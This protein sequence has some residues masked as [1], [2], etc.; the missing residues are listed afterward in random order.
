[1]NI[2][3]YRKQC[4]LTFL[5]VFSGT[6]LV[7][8]QDILWDKSY[9]GIHAEYLF[10]AQ[11]T[12]DYGFILVGSSISDRSGNKTEGN[13]Y[14]LDYWI[15]K[16]DEKG[17]LDWQ[18]SFGGNGND[19]LKSIDLTQDGGFI[20]GGHSTSMEGESKR[21]DTRGQ[22]DLWVIKLNARGDEE[23]QKTIGGSGKDILQQIKQTRDGGYI[24]GASSS[25]RPSGE[26]K[27]AHY[28][29]MDFWV[30][31]L[32]PQGTVEWERSFGGIYKDELKSIS[33]TEDEGFIVG[34]YSN[35]ILSGNKNEGSFGEGDFWVIKL[36][37]YGNQEWQRTI[38]GEDDDVLN[39]IVPSKN[40][41]YLVAG[42]SFSGATGRKSET[43]K[44]GSDFWVLKLDDRGEIE[45]QQTY[46]FGKTDV[47]TS[48]VENND[49]TI[50]IGGHAKSETVGLS[51][52][53]QRGIND[54]IALKIKPDGEEIWRKAVGSSGED[55]LRK[56]VET[57]DG[58]YILAG[59]SRGTVSG[60]RNS[61][62]GRSDFWV[63]KLKDKDK[64][65]KTR[66]PGLEAIPNPTDRFSNVIV[67]HDFDEG[68]VYVYDIAGRLLQQFPAESRTI[69]VDMAG[70]PIGIYLVTVATNVKTQS[71]KILKGN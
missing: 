43:N 38:G 9:G 24:I 59:T 40:G 69:P 11:P 2:I 27:S 4:F 67:N 1:M 44:N 32:D 42:S 60:D 20:L 63:V 65:D 70:F 28:G 39:T 52:N 36:N 19:V 37:K 16:M 48:L 68:S 26:K 15:W 23:W 35:S 17:D 41:G 33:Q 8:P 29:N 50:L 64:E 46:D 51:R 5:F 45:W 10:D 62:Q 66:H 54:Y 12:A 7:F 58:G 22:E 57:R 56:L 71:V 34:G 55:V 31:K 30:I 61:R 47:L 14:G 21:E 25:S 18:K 6:L 3:P 53:D 13:V 49:G